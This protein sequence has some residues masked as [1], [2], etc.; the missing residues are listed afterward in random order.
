VDSDKAKT[1]LG[2]AREQILDYYIQS[3]FLRK[4]HGMVQYVRN[5]ARTFDSCTACQAAHEN[6]SPRHQVETNHSRIFIGLQW[7]W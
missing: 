3:S 1:E 4:E 2:H 5:A 6:R 7:Q